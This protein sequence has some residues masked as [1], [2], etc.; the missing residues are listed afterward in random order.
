MKKI[1]YVGIVTFFMFTVSISGSSFYQISSTYPANPTDVDPLVDLAIDIHIERVRKIVI[2]E[3][4]SFS[5]KIMVGEQ[6][7]EGEIVFHG[8]DVMELC[9][10]HFDVPD[11]KEEILILIEVWEGERKGDISADGESLEII[12]NART[13]SWNGDD[14]V[15]DASGYGH[16]SG[17]EDGDIT[18]LDYEIW[19]DIKFND[20]DNDGLTYWEEVN[21]YGTDPEESDLGEDYDNDSLPIEW[22][23]KYGY[24][25][26]SRDNHVR[27]DSDVDGLTNVEEYEMKGWFADPFRQDIFIEVDCM[28]PAN[29]IQH[30]M[31]KKSIQM[32][33]SAF[34]KH[35]IVLLLDDGCMG[36]SDEIPLD[37]ALD[38]D[39]LREIYE[40]Y[41]LHNDQN[42]SRKG[43]FHYAI[44]CHEI[45]FWRRPA[46]GMNFM[47]DAF[48]IGSAYIQKWRPS[49]EGM[50]IAHASLFMHELGHSLDLNHYIGVDNEHTRFPWQ[51]QYWLFG[52]YKS[53]MNYRY[54]F[55]LIDYSDG[56]HGFLDYDDWGTLD[57][58][59]FE[60]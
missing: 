14:F 57:L 41:F 26:F 20:Y 15:E 3:E 8:Y 27:L 25:P 34:T 23:D 49:K 29:G 39:E 4:P 53:C 36:G 52:N 1:F 24:D 50:E 54:A 30:I 2:E 28:A 55:T 42:N 45:V 17:C 16:S 51:L 35:N 12:Y 9:T 59:R 33:Y 11:D 21:V 47:R 60:R 56:T 22:E 7:W 37:E 32:L 40:T 5:I 19:F 6:S 10:A 46:G 44:I 38:W 48:V 18:D 31:P 13:G 43:V 58:Q